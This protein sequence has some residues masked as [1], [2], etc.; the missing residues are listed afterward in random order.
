MPAMA[1]RLTVDDG[2]VAAPRGR[3]CTLTLGTVK[4][5]MTPRAIACAVLLGSAVCLTNMYFGLQAGIVNSMPMQSAL[6]G[7]AIFQSLRHRL[8]EPL[9]PM[10]ATVIE[11]I[12]SAIG[13]A[14]FTSG[15]TSFIPALEFLATPA[16][17]GPVS[18]SLGGLLLWAVAICGLGLV[19]GAP[20][21]NLFILREQLRYPSATATGTLIGV[22]FRRGDMTAR[23]HPT[24]AGGSQPPRSREAS[25][26]PEFRE[27][28]TNDEPSTAGPGLASADLNERFAPEMSGPGIRVLVYSLAGST[29]F[30]LV[31][32]LLPILR[33]LPIFGLA[34]SRDWLWAFDLS[35]AYI[36]YGIVVGPRVN[37]SILL[38]AVIGW[39]ILS[40][41]AK[42]HGWAPGPVGDWDSGSR[43]WILWV[44]MGLLL[45]DTLVGLGWI[46]LKPL[47][48]RAWH[49][50]GA[51]HRRR[52][53]RPS[54]EP[55]ERVGLLNDG[56][57]SSHDENEPNADSAEDD[58][59]PFASLVSIALVIRT[60]GLLL[61][62]Y[63]ASLLVAFRDLV[64]TLATIFA[65][66]LVPLA[67]YMS[68]R[69]FGETDYGAALAIG[70]LA[71]LA[72]TLVVPP[73]SQKYT[74]ANLLLGGA[75]ESGA[76]QAAQ[77][78][79][80]FKT[81]YMTRTPPKAVLYAEMAGSYI[82][83]LMAVVL[84]KMYTS[85]KVVPGE[86]FGVPD[87]HLYIVASRL[88]R[89][90][91]LPS[92]AMSFASAAFLLGAAFGTLRIIA[93]KQWWRNLIPSGVAMAIGMYVVPA[94]TLPRVLGGVVLVV[95][96]SRFGIKNFTL[97][98]CATGL[99]L[100]QS[101]SSL[102]G[103][104]FDALRAP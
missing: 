24:G 66:L 52:N 75:I 103:L 70:R 22:L 7:F 31:S 14:P 95:G 48:L 38:G 65:M 61:V 98:C 26:D 36:G 18:F 39:G 83:V 19:A 72:I 101:L 67:S 77:Q 41:A 10:E 68:M 97:V 99:I 56:T 33:Q 81:A 3:T 5:A 84:Y 90:Q 86:A 46:T 104:L 11:V 28:G 91:G 47:F 88:I 49:E 6:L 42:H 54:P 96:R 63:L 92:M 25:P 15:C 43:G 93:D 17:N 12:A 74:S 89:Q 60:G 9:S 21:R 76:A 40:P 34:A 27:A 13:L 71:Q 4:E 45:G 69:S 73:Y 20:F 62:L 8:R 102:V 37:A 85:A 16:E 87:A 30:S 80:G 58:N 29:L 55:V 2:L 94:I 59:W 23:A 100:G 78:M 32:Y 57:N 64:S 53:C 82:G 50:P 44:G 79:G 35:P 1:A 51:R